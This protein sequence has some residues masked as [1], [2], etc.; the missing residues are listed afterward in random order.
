MKHNFVINR[1]VLTPSAEQPLLKPLQTESLWNAKN[2]VLEYFPSRQISVSVKMTIK[3][4]VIDWFVFHMFSPL[5]FTLM[6]TDEMAWY[7][8]KFKRIST[9]NWDFW[10]ATPW[11]HGVYFGGRPLKIWKSTRK[12][13]H[14]ETLVDQC[15]HCG[16]F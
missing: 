8:K 5:C 9:E 1:F 4:S 12:P 16:L 11:G 3:F 15:C 2:S 10:R 14:L 6:H 13:G 7:G